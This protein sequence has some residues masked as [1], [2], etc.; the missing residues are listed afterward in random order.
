MTLLQDQVVKLEMTRADGAIIEFRRSGYLP[1]VFV[2]PE[3]R[4]FR[5]QLLPLN[6]HG[7]AHCIKYESSSFMAHHVVADAYMPGWDADHPFLEH[8]D[9]N[10]QN[11]HPSNLRPSR[12]PRRGRPRSSKLLDTFRALTILLHTRD[13]RVTTEETGFSEEEML[14]A[15]HEYMPNILRRYK[16]IGITGISAK[17]VDR[18]G[19]PQVLRRLVREGVIGE[20]VADIPAHEIVG[21][22]EA[23]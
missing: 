10:R 19:M 9:G 22:V 13:L 3:G 7:G 1:D 6:N 5:L 15:M 23:R 20:D 18:I 14:V 21:R 12:D 16:E 17:S 11:N 2:C 8:I 4:I